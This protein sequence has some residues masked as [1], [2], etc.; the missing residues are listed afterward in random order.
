MDLRRFLCL[1]GTWNCNNEKHHFVPLFWQPFT[2]QNLIQV[3]PAMGW[4]TLKVSFACSHVSHPCKP[5]SNSGLVRGSFL[6]AWN[7]FII[8]PGK[9]GT[10]STFLRTGGKFSFF[11]FACRSR[12]HSSASERFSYCSG[13]GRGERRGWKSSCNVTFWSFRLGSHWEISL[14]DI[15]AAALLCFCFK[16]FFHFWIHLMVHSYY[17]TKI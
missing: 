2:R 16:V 8:V 1:G 10:S 11:H 5:Q 14:D 6:T 15:P 17:L 13:K 12:Y 9:R 3:F 7:I 4:A